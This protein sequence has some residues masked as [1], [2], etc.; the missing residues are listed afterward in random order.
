MVNTFLF[1]DLPEIFFVR[2]SLKKSEYKK[3]AFRI[4]SFYSLVIPTNEEREYNL[5]DER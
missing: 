2:L 4:F 1:L 3:Q 5:L